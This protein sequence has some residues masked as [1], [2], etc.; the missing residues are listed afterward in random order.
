[1]PGKTGNVG[2]GTTSP[3]QK[4]EVAGNITISRP[5]AAAGNKTWTFIYDS[6]AVCVSKRGWN[7]T[8]VYDGPC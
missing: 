2:I 3:G 4:L 6:A 8:H 5:A 7:G 1:M